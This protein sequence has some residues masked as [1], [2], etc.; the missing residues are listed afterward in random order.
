M[1]SRDVKTYFS[2]TKFLNHVMAVILVVVEMVF[3]GSNGDI[4]TVVLAV[5]AVVELVMVGIGSGR[6]L[7]F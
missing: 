6:G 1:F 7:R 5:V 4:G 2:V 3:K